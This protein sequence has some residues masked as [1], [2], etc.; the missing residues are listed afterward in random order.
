M[1]FLSPLTDPSA[2]VLSETPIITATSVTI[3]DTVPTPSVETGFV[4]EWQRDTSVGCSDVNQD[5]ISVNGVFISYTITGLEP[6]NSYLI[7]VRVYNVLGSPP[8]STVSAMTETIGKA[9]RGRCRENYLANL[10]PQLPLATPGTQV[11][12]SHQTASQSTGKRWTV[13]TVM[14]P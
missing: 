10:P 7:T 11:L 6:G 8:V 13:S 1:S 2:P 12:L 5:T 3:T 14:E 9:E 4:V